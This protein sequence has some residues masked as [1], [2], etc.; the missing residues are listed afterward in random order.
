MCQAYEAERN[1]IIAGEE[2]ATIEGYRA[3]RDG[4]LL[5]DNPNFPGY[6]H[7][8]WEHGWQCREEGIIPW[9]IVKR[10]REKVEAKNGSYWSALMPTK[11]QAD[12]IV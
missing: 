5:T 9:G 2:R 11:E 6:D 10:I 3:H 7:K 1:F 4:K 8:A 12:A